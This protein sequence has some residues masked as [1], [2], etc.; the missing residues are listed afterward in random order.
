MDT[1][2]VVVG[3]DGGP[4]SLRALQWAAEYATAVD[5]PL[6]ALTAYQLPNIYGPYAMAGWE[7]S[8]ELESS[9][10]EMLAHAVRSALG[11]DASVKSAVLQGHAAKSLIAASRDA[12]LV[13]V[14]S[15]GRG[16]FRGMVLGSVS[17]HV[18]P[19][20]HCPVVVLPHSSGETE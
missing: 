9:A 20:A 12:R 4:D 13:V 10:R 16:G 17:Q 5:A 3:V 7:G 15:R 1:R 11:D 14:G 18:V 6:V 19:H 8:S 2:P